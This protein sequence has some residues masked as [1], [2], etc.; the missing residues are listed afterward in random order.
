MAEAN[1]KLLGD[2][3]RRFREQA[4]PQTISLF[5]LYELFYLA[6]PER[7]KCQL[8]PEDYARF[9]KCWNEV[10]VGMDDVFPVHPHIK[11]HFRNGRDHVC[12][13]HGR[14]AAC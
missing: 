10:E 12:D 8:L 1:M 13:S 4:H 5:R 6:Y 7:M 9:V 14:V 2:G 3:I 11:M